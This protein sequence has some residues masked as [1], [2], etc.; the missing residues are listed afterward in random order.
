MISLLSTAVVEYVPPVFSVN[1]E[2]FC[3]CSLISLIGV[4]VPGV[5]CITVVLEVCTSFY[6]FREI[7]ELSPVDM[8]WDYKMSNDVD[9]RQTVCLLIRRILLKA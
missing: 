5:L 6:V 7:V 1:A 3:G 8:S 4:V 9:G 2:E